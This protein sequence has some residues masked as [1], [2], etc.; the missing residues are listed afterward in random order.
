MAVN[1]THSKVNTV[2]DGSDTSPVRPSDWNANHVVPT[3]TR[4]IPLVPVVLL[5][6][7]APIPSLDI[8]TSLNG[9][10]HLHF[11]DG[12]DSGVYYAEVPVPADDSNAAAGDW[13]LHALWSS[14]VGGNNVWAEPV[15]VG[16]TMAGGDTGGF[17]TLDTAAAIAADA[18]AD[19]QKHT[20]WAFGALPGART[21]S[22]LILFTRTNGGDTNTGQVSLYNAWL[23]YKADI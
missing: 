17:V 11:A 15:V 16:F 18:A 2:A 9:F 5:G 21:L 12:V 1:I 7:G 23:E 22:V 14:T 10:P 8:H 6:G 19:K 4:R 3:R 13:V 20:T